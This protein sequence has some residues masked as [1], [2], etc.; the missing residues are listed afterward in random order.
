MQ[1]ETL[2]FNQLITRWSSRN[3]DSLIFTSRVSTL[4]YWQILSSAA[5][6]ATAFVAETSEIDC[7]MLRST[8]CD[9]SIATFL[10]VYNLSR[11]LDITKLRDILF[12]CTKRDVIG[13]WAPPA[14]TADI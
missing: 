10:L 8:T 3:S 9:T 2:V 5:S 14:R 7:N 1:I 12:L 6:S 4:S 13:P 11:S